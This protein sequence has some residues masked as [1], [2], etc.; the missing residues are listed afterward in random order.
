MKNIKKINIYIAKFI[1]TPKYFFPLLVLVYFLSR[2]PVWLYPFDS[3]HWIFYYVGKNWF[4]GGT[5]YLTAWD[6]KP[7]IIFLING[8][9]SVILGDNIILHRILFSFVGLFSVYLMYL[10]LKLVV[11]RFKLKSPQLAINTGILI[12]VILTNVAQFTSSGN[13]TENF[14]LPFLIG[15][16]LSYLSF[17]NSNKY[18]QLLVSGI[19]LSFMFFLKGNFL[20]LAMPIGFFVIFDNLKNIKKM[21][22]DGFIFGLPLFLHSLIWIVYFALHNGLQDFLIATFIFS[23]KYSGSAWVGQLSSMKTFYFM[24][25]L[26]SPIIIIAPIY[27]FFLFKKGRKIAEYNFFALTLLFCFIAFFSVGLPYLYYFLIAMPIYTIT[28]IY[29][30]FSD[31]NSYRVVGKF[32]YTWFLCMFFAGIILLS[33]IS[34][35]QLPALSSENTNSEAIE[36]KNIAQYVNKNTDTNDTV[37]AND[38]G[39]TFYRLSDRDSGSRFISASVLLLDYRG[40]YGF[41][42]NDL[43]ISDAEKSKPKYVVVYKDKSS[44]YYQNKPIVKYFSGHYHL[45]KSFN[46]FEVLR[47]N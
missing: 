34:M 44:L 35:R 19:C 41:H 33:I 27:Y 20:L 47:R 7:P 45:E 6:H 46:K 11:P 4:H 43:F 8:L 10:L 5:L 31:H 21:F 38:Y 40:N 22:M 2:L 3:D 26:A 1:N 12:F 39:G 29:S 24:V 37:F 25:S 42:L 16:I 32:I 17:R 14:A 13:D 36:Y 28:A 30:I 15:M 9:M 18:W 23:A